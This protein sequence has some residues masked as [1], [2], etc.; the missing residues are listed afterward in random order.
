M[1]GL[2]GW[3]LAAAGSECVFGDLKREDNRMGARTMEAYMEQST[4]GRRRPRA[5]MDVGSIAV[6]GSLVEL[7]K[8]YMVP[9]GSRR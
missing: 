4:N 9:H 6:V 2:I 1:L 7:S 8:S 3:S 5:I